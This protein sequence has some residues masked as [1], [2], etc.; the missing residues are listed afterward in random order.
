M[1]ATSRQ[2]RETVGHPV[3]D[4]DGHMLEIVAAA[5][6]F[7]RRHLGDA[8]YDRW[9]N[10]TS[11]VGRNTAHRTL[12]ERQRT[13]EPQGAWWGTHTANTLERA[14]ATLPA[15]MH[16]R[17]DEFGIDVS[18]LY[19][20]N[21]LT[22]CGIPD[23]PIRRGL[24]AAY[25]EF[26]A[27][28]YGPF[29]DRLLPAG[30]IPMHTPAEAV[31]EIEHCHALG[32]K[33][34][35]L[36]EGVLRPMAEPA[37][38]D[39]SAWLL[40]GQA[41]WFDTYGLDSEHDY[42]PVWSAA[43]RLGFAI[44][45]HGGLSVRP[46]VYNSI[47][48]YVANHIGMFAALMY[49]LCKSLFLGGVTRRFPRL[50]FVFLECGVSW[51]AQMLY[52]TIEHWEKRNV[53]AM[54]AFD[55]ARLDRDALATLI[56]RHGGRLLDLMQTDPVELLAKLPIH[57]SVPEEP[58][59]WIHLDVDGPDDI[60]DAFVDSFFFGCEADDRGVLTAFSPANSGGRDLRPIFS[61]DIGHWDVRDSARV[62]AES[63]ELVDAGHL[64]AEQYRKFVFE[65]AY[66][67]F[68]RVNPTFFD[69][70]PVAAHLAAA[71]RS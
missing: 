13:R 18:I 27:E 7:V 28:I 71:D 68:T 49:P 32:L 8:L 2:V 12:A 33:V 38:P 30:M 29:A 3:I 1:T 62:V 70:T 69:G 55:P 66:E 26:F 36:P 19:P 42:D 15:L 52:D 37:G 63:F 24:C 67:M 25:N 14:T 58:D 20:T 56:Q 65:N 53:I 64:T 9:T 34:I 22:T 61:S 23:E 50:P 4:A 40:P 11:L 10:G 35:A 17:M 60:V 21:T 6:P 5:Q 43:E 57:A 39:S 47:S 54:E 45:F 51:G 44:T 59:E 41:H 31:A 48:S 46:G 16:S